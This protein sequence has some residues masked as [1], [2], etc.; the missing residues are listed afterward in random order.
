MCGPFSQRYKMFWSIRMEKSTKIC[1]AY[2]GPKVD[3]GSM[4]ASTLGT[5]LISM[6]ALVN[7]ANRLL[8][9]DNSSIDVRVKADFQKGS[10]EIV[11]ALIQ[12]LPEQIKSLFSAGYSIDQIAQF[13][14]LTNN[15]I[16]AA[17]AVGGGIFWLIKKLRNRKIA[18]V[19]EKENGQVEVH[20]DKGAPFLVYKPVY[21]LFVD[22]DVRDVLPGLVKPLEQDGINHFEVRDIHQMIRPIMSINKEECEY[23][24]EVPEDVVE[25]KCSCS[26]ISVTVEAAV[27]DGSHKWK[28]NDGDTSFTATVAD[29]DFLEKIA[30]GQIR[31][32]PQ[33]LLDVN[34]EKHQQIK[35]HRKLGR[36]D[37][38][39]TKVIKYTQ[40]N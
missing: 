9:N 28:F 5:V 34:L 27:F 35:N 17:G 30:K 29:K 40:Q 2:C 33:D 25:E 19:V 37:N 10:F 24:K 21:N 11:L 38:V 31:L 36:T 15:G 14:D 12:T 26:T 8:N 13:L 4:D 3:D 7:Q 1:I 22:K 20:P 18:K 16:E 39:I 6:S 23:I 32:G